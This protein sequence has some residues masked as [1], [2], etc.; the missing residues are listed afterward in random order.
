M[1]RAK[2]WRKKTALLMM[3]VMLAGIFAACGS[4]APASSSQA[5]PPASNSTPNAAPAP[6]S[7][8]S[9][10]T[11]R[12][13]HVVQEGSAPDAGSRKF[14]D[15]VYEKTNGGIVIEI[16]T[17]GTLGQNREMIEML[18]NGTLDFT[19]PTVA[20]LS[21]F[22][23]RTKILDLPFLFKDV[24]S[25]EKVL[26]GEIGKDILN[27]LENNELIGLGWYSQGWRQT[28]ANKAIRTPDDFKGIKIRTQ[29]NTLHIAG[30]NQLGASAIPMAFSEV[31]TGLQ[32][33]T[34]D[35]QENPYT[36]IYLN[37]YY[38]VQSHVIETRHVYDSIALLMSKRTFDSLTPDEQT[39][40]REA[41]EEACAYERKYV[42]EKDEESKQ[43]II[44]TGK[45][46]IVELTP[47][48]WDVFRAAVQPV[49]DK[50]ASEVG[51]A[52]LNQILDMQK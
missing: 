15:L 37:A 13:G 25:A 5:A 2:K 49:Y 23:D 39:A 26:T 16:F 17:G 35:A 32:Q 31:F 28:T 48:E 20:V 22:T 21:G 18:Q 24:E 50:Y 42:M 45:T 52:L 47:A 14:A 9:V 7:A 1:Y 36:N 10:R 29:D 4:P 8:G 46:E 30:F 19:H 6:S 41:A 51:E 38:E 40:I 12:L 3:L 34:I 44:A 33:K 11:L 27:S 43:A